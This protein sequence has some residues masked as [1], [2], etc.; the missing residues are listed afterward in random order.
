MPRLDVYGITPAT[1]F[2]VHLGTWPAGAFLIAVPPIFCYTN[3]KP[4]TK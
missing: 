2:R 1:V 3:E 4:Y